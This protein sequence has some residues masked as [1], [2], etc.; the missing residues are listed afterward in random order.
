MNTRVYKQHFISSHETVQGLL[1]L[2]CCAEAGAVVGC[3][4]LAF[5]QQWCISTV[6]WSFDI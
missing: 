5:C 3:S 4:E 6:V 2:L 1:I